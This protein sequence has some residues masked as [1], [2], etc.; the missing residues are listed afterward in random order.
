MRRGPFGRSAG[1]AR[2][3]ARH[4]CLQ[5]GL[6]VR[7][8][9]LQ[10]EPGLAALALVG[11]LFGHDR[12][13][14]DEPVVHLD[15]KDLA[16]ALEVEDSPERAQDVSVFAAWRP[17]VDAHRFPLRLRRSDS[18]GRDQRAG[19]PDR[20]VRAVSQARARQL[21]LLWLPVLTLAALIFLLSAQSDV[22]FSTDPAIDW[23]VRKAAHVTIFAA[24]AFLVM[25]ALNGMR[26]RDMLLIG[27]VLTATYAAS[28]E[29]HQSFVVGRSPLVTDVLIDVLGVLIGIVAWRRWVARG[30]RGARPNASGHGD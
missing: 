25:R 16:D 13:A 20:I 29:V 17:F 12:A 24:L 22:H 19:G 21:L 27:F 10:L 9:E 15:E 14:R 23:P 4:R 8:P 28:D 18:T 1:I 3:S 11:R 26:V 6:E 30:P 5:V 7:V 2:A